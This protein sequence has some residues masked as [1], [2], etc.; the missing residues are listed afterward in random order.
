MVFLLHFK[1]DRLLQA[2]NVDKLFTNTV[3]LHNKE[4]VIEIWALW[5]E[6][7]M[8][9]ESEEYLID[10]DI[11]QYCL[12]QF[13]EKILKVQFSSIELKALLIWTFLIDRN[14]CYSEL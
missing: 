6:C 9:L 11:L 2:D 4:E 14:Y 8:M 3:D 1:L 10:L 12:E 7:L 13:G 5:N